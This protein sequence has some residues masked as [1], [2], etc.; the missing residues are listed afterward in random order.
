M[1]SIFDAEVGVLRFIGYRIR[2]EESSAGFHH[3]LTSKNK[4]PCCA[5]FKF[6]D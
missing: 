2:W 5:V 1:I 4:S 6:E 3:V